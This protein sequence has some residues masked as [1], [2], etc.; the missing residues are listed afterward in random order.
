MIGRCLSR[1]RGQPSTRSASSLVLARRT[2]EV[3][4]DHRSS[5]DETESHGL[6]ASLRGNRRTAF[7]VRRRCS[8]PR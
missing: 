5:Q 2:P 8:L 3:R 6:F 1:E 4:Y 7:L